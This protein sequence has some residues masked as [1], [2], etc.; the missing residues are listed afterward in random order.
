MPGPGSFLTPG[1]SL[2]EP[3]RLALYGARML[4]RRGRADPDDAASL[5]DADAETLAGHV[6]RHIGR[7]ALERMIS[8]VFRVTRGW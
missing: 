2:S 5:P 8:P 1:P 6:T 4:A 3:A 7:T